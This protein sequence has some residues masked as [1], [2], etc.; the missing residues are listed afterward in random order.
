M[1]KEKF[2]VKIYLNLEFSKLKNLKNEYKIKNL[3]NKI[4]KKI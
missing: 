2:Y 3:K 4:V 1:G